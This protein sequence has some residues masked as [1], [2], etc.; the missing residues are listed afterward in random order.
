MNICEEFQPNV[1]TAHG[2]NLKTYD[3]EATI[4]NITINQP[5]PC[6]PTADDLTT[7]QGDIDDIVTRLIKGPRRKFSPNHSLPSEVLIMVLCPH[8]ISKPSIDK[9]GVGERI[10]K[11]E[12]MD[13]RM[14]FTKWKNNKPKLENS[15]RRWRRGNT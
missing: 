15:G 6:T 5:N 7:A 3:E 14:R 12:A 4:N 9:G 11:F 13:E 10:S 8:Y 1:A 2:Q